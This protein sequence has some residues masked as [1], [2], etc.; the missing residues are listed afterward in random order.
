MKKKVKIGI[1]GLGYVGLPLFLEFSKKFN[2]KGFDLSKKKVKKLYQKKDFTN[3]FS[4]KDLKK[5]SQKNVSYNSVILKN[6]NFFIVTVPTPLNS[7][8]LPDLSALISATKTVSKYIKDRGY[9]VYESTVY[10]GVTEDICIKIIEKQTGLKP[11][12]DLNNKLKK[13]FYYGYSP[14]RINPGDAKHNLK[15]IIKITSGGTKSSAKFI[16]NLYKKIC[17]AGTYKAKSV[18]V[19]EGA[20]VI[21]NTQRDINIALVNEFSQIFSKMNI[22]TYDVLQAA[23][24]KWNFLNFKP[25]LVGGH[26]IGID[27]YYLA[28]KAKRVGYNSKLILAGRKL[29]D[30]MHIFVINKLFKKLK[31]NFKKKKYKILIAGL[32]F[33]ENINDFR[34]SRSI[35]LAKII[36]KKRHQLDVFDYNVSIK[37]F[38]KEHNLNI[39]KKPKKN[40]YD[41]VLIAVTHKKFQSQKKEYFSSLLKDKQKGVIFDMKN[42]FNSK[43]F[44]SL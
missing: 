38:R 27:P 18:R 13:G 14:E 17:L 40:F 43:K 32:S 44:I 34:N 35:E 37:D 26:C 36:K 7:K 8:K 31:N 39:I 33:K 6:C 23:K 29:N 22:N 41:A 4:K 20:K 24:T 1:I 25:G 15:R 2:V 16:D 10:P 21:E 11:F 5:I 30:E 3:Q 28:F 42:I 12:N 9:V 19:A